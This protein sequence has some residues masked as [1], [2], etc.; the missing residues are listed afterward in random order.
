MVDTYPVGLKEDLTR[1]A[2]T[3]K[4]CRVVRN[5][6]KDEGLLSSVESETGYVFRENSRTELA[7]VNV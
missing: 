6:L 1:A 5:A 4:D 3:K 2:Q 7:V